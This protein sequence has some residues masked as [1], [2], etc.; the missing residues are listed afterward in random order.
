MHESASRFLTNIV[1]DNDL[2]IFGIFDPNDV[3]DIVKTT[4][5]IQNSQ[6]LPKLKNHLEIILKMVKNDKMALRMCQYGL[7]EQ[8]LE[9]TEY[10]VKA[11]SIENFFFDLD[12][13]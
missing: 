4:K 3:K 7:S 12:G 6:N 11:N 9:V 8:L 10:L 1:S 2:D 13:Q 5:D